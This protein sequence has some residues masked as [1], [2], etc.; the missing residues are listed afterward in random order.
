MKVKKYHDGLMKV[1]N[2]ISMLKNIH[3]IWS[4]GSHTVTHKDLQGGMQEA[5]LGL[6]E[7]KQNSILM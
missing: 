2:I 4:S 5:N 6:L 3:I 7:V 1:K